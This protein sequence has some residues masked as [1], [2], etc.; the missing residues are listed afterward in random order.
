MQ[1]LPMRTNGWI[2]LPSKMK[3]FS[4][5]SALRQTKARAQAIELAGRDRDEHVDVRRRVM[6]FQRL[7]GQHRTARQHRLREVFA[8]DAEGHHVMVAVVFEVFAGDLCELAR[9]DQD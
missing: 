4:P 5:S 9:A 1:L 7:P 2:T 6:R 3:L 8:F